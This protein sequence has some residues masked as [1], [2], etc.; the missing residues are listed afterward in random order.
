MK[1][2]RDGLRLASMVLVLPLV[3]AS[4]CGDDDSPG[5]DA[6]PSQDADA[7]GT[8]ATAD[9]DYSEQT[10]EAGA[11]TAK[12]QPE[13]IDAD[14]AVFTVAFDTHSEE[15]D[16]DVAAASELV[17]GG[18]AWTGAEWEGDPPGGH[19]REGR[20]SFESTGEPTG[21]AVLT[22]AGLPAPVEA[23]WDVV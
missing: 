23:T 15:L 22:L 20:L 10:I 9:A 12:I 13:R 7:S 19:H 6:T 11:V 16:L 2:H 14:G 8:D 3:L 21:Q 17:V 1:V 4:G 18:Q 5:R